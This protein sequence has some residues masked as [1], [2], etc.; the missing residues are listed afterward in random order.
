MNQ[1]SQKGYILEYV[2]E[3]GLSGIALVNANTSISA[4]NI[5]KRQGIFSSLGYKVGSATPIYNNVC[6]NPN[7]IIGEAVSGKGDKG[8][9][10]KSAYDI[11][12][13]HG[14]KGTEEEWL[15]SLKGNKEVKKEFRVDFMDFIS[16]AGTDSFSDSFIEK[17]NITEELIDDILKGDYSLVF[18]YNGDVD[19]QNNFEMYIQAHLSAKQTESYPNGDY[20]KIVHSPYKVALAD[21]GGIIIGIFKSV[22]QEEGTKMG[23]YIA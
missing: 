10:G 12:V 21:S 1:E 9:D 23:F 13:E 16:E 7:T 2:T 8:D 18:Y 19:S 15:E 5:L 17:Y 11:A 4:E 14:F 3:E 6:I 22:S 20:T